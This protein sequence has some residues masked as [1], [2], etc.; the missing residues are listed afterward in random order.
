MRVIPV[1][2]LCGCPDYELIAAADLPTEAGDVGVPD[3]VVTP[4]AIDFGVLQEGES[5]TVLVTI[6]NVGDELLG[7]NGLDFSEDD[8]PFSLSSITS[9]LIPPAGSAEVSVTV[10]ANAPGAIEGSLLIDSIDP[11]EPRVEVVLTAEVE[12]PEEPYDTAVIEEPEDDCECPEGYTMRPAMDGCFKVTTE[13]ATYNGTPAHVC[14][15]TPYFAYGYFGV[16]YPG[17]EN[18]QDGYWGQNDSVANGPLNRVGIWGCEAGDKVAGNDPIGEWIGFGVCLDLKEP[19]DYLLGAGADNRIRLYI[20]GALVFERDDGQTSSFNYWWL[21]GIS[22]DS[23]THV[24]ELYGKNDG[25]IAGFGA[26]VVGP[27]PAGATAADDD[28]VMKLDYAS[29]IFWSTADAVGEAF[30]LGEDSGWSCPDGTHFDAC[31][32]EPTC[33]AVET[34]ECE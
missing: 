29:N 20:D 21:T 8:A 34:A 18:I 22:L 5:A 1:L 27:F 24:V 28:E 15:I 30:S 10:Y 4:S 16:R 26:E 23:G 12:E 14:P 31:A 33:I 13:D 32:E 3:I 9:T 6:A 19:G 2:L 17:G 25:S 11:D 7:L